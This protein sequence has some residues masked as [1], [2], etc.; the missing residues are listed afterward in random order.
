MY[1]ECCDHGGDRRW[2][3]KIKIED[4]VDAQCLELNDHRG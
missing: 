1:L 4:V 2:G 3:R